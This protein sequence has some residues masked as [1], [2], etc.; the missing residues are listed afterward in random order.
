[1][2]GKIFAVIAIALVLWVCL[3]GYGSRNEANII[4]D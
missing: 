1:M 2:K 3:A 4:T